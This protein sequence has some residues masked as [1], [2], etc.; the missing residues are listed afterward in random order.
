MLKSILTILKTKSPLNCPKLS[1]KGQAPIILITMALLLIYTATIGSNINLSSKVE[2]N[3]AF[4]EEDLKEIESRRN[5]KEGELTG[6]GKDKNLIV[7]QVEALQNFVIALD[8]NGQEITPNL[9][10]LIEDQSSVYYDKYYQLLGRGNTSDSEFVSHNSFHPSMEEPSYIKYEKNKFYG[11]PLL[12]KDNGYT[13]WAMHGYEKEYWNRDKAYKNQGFERFLSKED[14]KINNPIGFGLS[15][16]DFFN[17]SLEYL[18]QLDKIDENP[19]Y[20]F[21]VTLTSHTPFN[22]PREYQKLD[23]LP[24]HEDKLLGNYLQSIHYTD[25]QIGKFIESLKK[26]GLYD[27]TVIAIYG[28][29]FAISSVSEENQEMMTELLDK[30]YNYD[31]MMNIPLIVHVPGEDINTKISTTGSQIDFYPTM[32]NIMG[33]KNEKGLIFGRDL[34]NYKEYNYVAPQTYMLKGSLIDDETVFVMSRDGIFDHSKAYDLNTQ[35]KVDIPQMRPIYEKAIEEI[36]KSDF[37]LNTNLLKDYMEN[38]G[39]V[40]LDKLRGPKILNSKYIGKMDYD[41]LEELIHYYEKGYKLLSLELKRGEDEEIIISNSNILLS[42]LEE[43]I[44]KHDDA[45]IIFTTKEDE[46]L[47]V[48]THIKYKEIRE[49]IVLEIKNFSS[50]SQLTSNG[51]AN[52]IL[53]PIENEYKDGEILDF[54]SKHQHLGVLL[55]RARGNTSLP[56]Q[57]KEKG[58]ASYIDGPTGRFSRT[59]LERKVDGFV[60]NP[61]EEKAINLND[62]KASKYKNPHVVAHGG[63]EIGSRTYSNSVEALNKSYGKGIRLMEIDFEWTTDDELVALHSWD[64]FVTGFFNKPVRKYSFEEFK[65]FEMINGWH[66]LTLES[67]DRWFEQHSDAYLVTD[68]KERNVEALKRLKE[69]YPN[70]AKNTIPQVYQLSEYEEVKKLGYDNIILTLYIIRS[71]EDEIVSFVENNELFAVTMPVGRTK[72]DLLKRIKDNGTYVYAHTVNSLDEA[73]E[74]EKLGVSGFYSDLLESK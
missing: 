15:D 57:L 44:K 33:Y 23:I 41:S 56:R 26:E 51:F 70:L 72:T 73:D 34:T 67:V 4:T 17:Q 21:M 47:L 6:I 52:V 65:N 20:S 27:D 25:R 60:I 1:K 30:N 53:N 32:M 35:A 24:E 43:W 55:D 40:D 66:Q 19:F 50:Y 42:D 37:I 71:T 61:K 3:S 8:Y 11:L 9:N 45:H 68:I 46:S 29:H 64:G 63:G 16:E 2:A 58:I 38:D 12:L 28:D 54:I 13:S 74:L 36:N 10:K 62:S 5:L 69:E 14:Y 59:I 18:K 7:L 39:Q 49:N 31:E 22:M 48:E